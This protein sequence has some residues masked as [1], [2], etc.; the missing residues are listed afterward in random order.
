MVLSRYRIAA[1]GELAVLMAMSSVAAPERRPVR[2]RVKAGPPHPTSRQQRRALFR[3]AKD[4]LARLSP[5]K[6]PS[7]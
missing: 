1:L 7:A 4:A 2:Y 6:E 3:Q 5:T